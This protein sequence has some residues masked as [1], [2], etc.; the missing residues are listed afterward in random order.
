MR[1]RGVADRRLRRCLVLVLL[2][3][4][5]L[6]GCTY[7]PQEPGLFGRETAPPTAAPASVSETPTET[8]PPGNRELPVVG[9]AVWTSGDGLD[10]TIRLA[11]H[12]VRRMPHAT[13]LDWSV[14]PLSGPNLGANDAVPSSLNLGLSRFGEGNTNV[15]LLDSHARR[16]YRPLTHRGPG[17]QSCLCTPVWLVQRELRIGHTTLLQTAYPPLPDDVFTID[18]DIATVP[19]FSRVPVT[20][21]GMVPVVGNTTDLNR[22]VDRAAAAASTPVFTYRPGHQRFIITIDAVYVSS[23]FTSI[24]WSIQSVDGGSG[25]EA[26]DGPPFA[27]DRPPPLAYN[28]V[29]ASGPQVLVNSGDEPPVRA[30]LAT[31]KLAGRGALECLCSDL[32]LWATA[33]R[34][35]DQR[36]QVV[37]NLPAISVGSSSVD[38]A[39]PGLATLADISL[40]TAPDSTFRSAGRQPLPPSYWAVRPGEAHPGWDSAAWPTPLPQPDQLKDFRATVDDI[41]R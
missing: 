5:A 20:P 19:I 33:M 3:A 34:R 12:A 26:A 31:T 18:V 7:N 40:T 35:A 32:R 11:V 4:C 15:F 41:V 24:L 17:L 9:E 16:L 37:T 27:D 21:A 29:S 38:I 13:V 30:R 36:V 14:T 2:A 23:S 10:I 8:P 25:L 28:P 6:A 1:Y 39:L 22:P